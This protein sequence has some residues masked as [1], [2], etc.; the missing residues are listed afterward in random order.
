MWSVHLFHVQMFSVPS[1]LLSCSPFP[2]EETEE[3][4]DDDEDLG[5][6]SDGK[7]E[8]FEIQH[9]VEKLEV[10]SEHAQSLPQDPS[11]PVPLFRVSAQRPSG[12]RLVIPYPRRCL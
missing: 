2:V 11:L 9:E 5:Q 6:A 3:G 4:D 12:R 1:L 7:V 8:K 10:E